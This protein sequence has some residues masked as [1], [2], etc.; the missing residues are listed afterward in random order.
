MAINRIKVAASPAAVFEVLS[1]PFTYAGWVVGTSEITGADPDWP[2]IGSTFSY[3]VGVPPAV[4]SGIT[5][6]V[7]YEEDRLL[8]LRTVLPI[9][10]VAIEIDVEETDG[11]SYIT[12]TE[13]PALRLVQQVLDAGF[14]VRN[15]QSL[16]YL[17]GLVEERTPRLLDP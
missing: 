9:G 12:M 17:K 16:A 3:R 14:H 5:E 7:A 13:V 10:A 4:W 15:A 2:E 11:G 1:D 6:V 8:S